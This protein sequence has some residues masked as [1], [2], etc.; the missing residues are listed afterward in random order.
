MPRNGSGQYIP[1]TNTWN[2]PVTGVLATGADFQ[3]QLTDIAAAITQSFSKDGQ[4][5][6]TGSL[7]M[8]NNSIIGV[9]A[10]TAA[11]P[12]I[13]P[14]GDIN[15]GVYFP[16]ADHVAIS[17]GGTQRVVVD[18]S[19]NVGVG[20]TPS[21]WGGNYTALQLPFATNLAGYSGGGG[22]TELSHNARF[23]GTDW[24]Y[25]VSS[26]ATKL[27]TDGNGIF[28]WYSATAGTAGS[29]IP[30]GDPKM[31]L[32]ANGRL[33]LGTATPASKLHI[34][35]TND[36]ISSISG[37]SIE[38]K[39]FITN[40]YAGMLLYTADTANA[41]M[42]AK[43]TGSYQGSL[44]FGVNN[45][46]SAGSLLERL[47]L[48]YQGALKPTTD[49][50]QTL[51]TASNR[52]SVVYAATGIINT[53]DERAKLDF[54][55]TLGL[56]FILKLEP[57]SYRYKKGKTVIDQVEDG[58]EEVPAVLDKDG[59]EV[60]P[61]TTIPKYKNVERISEGKRRYHGL[62]AQQVKQTLD[63]FGVDF[64]GWILTDPEDPE[65]EQGLRYDQF[66]APL[67]KSIKE[68]QVIIDSLTARIAVL[69]AK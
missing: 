6:M 49:N 52:W 33:G 68:Q 55:D 3:A 14:T 37:I 27:T 40:T 45:G 32:A 56:D 54:A 62:K 47:I 51:G 20:V 24:R 36:T 38:N 12:S 41:Y 58:V 60:T 11:A 10:G 64:A 48:D 46:S 4:T 18:A 30:F 65:S 5:P 29:T 21:A 35:E 26:G 39:S 17:T 50:G 13:S 2:P 19:G 66:I 23:D 25:Q 53:S 22:R 31:T 8:N 43:R 57:V 7:P 1:L 16:T 67:I 69:E 42:V 63:Q 61:A 34:S 44:S 28:N 59:N 9:A 15:T